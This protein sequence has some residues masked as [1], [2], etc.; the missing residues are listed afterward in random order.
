MG[1]QEAHRGS[2]LPTLEQVWG[3]LLSQR[4][5]EVGR[6]VVAGYSTQQIAQTLY[7]SENTV[8]T[9]LRN[10]YRKTKT[11]SRMELYRKLVERGAALTGERT[12]AKSLPASF[13]RLF[14]ELAGRRGG[15]AQTTVVLLQLEFTQQEKPVDPPEDAVT[16]LLSTSI[17]QLDH[18]V[19]W[20]ND[21]YLLVLPG[22]DRACAHQVAERL[23]RKLQRWVRLKD[24]WVNAAVGTASLD[25]DGGT[26][27][28]VVDL[29]ARRLRPLELN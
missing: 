17:R 6:L 1:T 10:L 14:T 28:A 7:I 9:H 27:E 12:F 26:P 20:R 24:M 8:K 21:L 18:L 23:I 3:P 11:H 13:E 5:L 2:A 19:K 29:A 25:E 15:G 16:D 22:S 4:E